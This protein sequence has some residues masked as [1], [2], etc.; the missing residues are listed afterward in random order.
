MGALLKDE[1]IKGFEFSDCRVQ[2]SRLAVL[3]ACDAAERGADIFTRTKVI[4]A[5]RDGK[6]WKI[7]LRDENGS[8]EIYA[9]ALVNAGGPWMADIV[10]NTVN[11]E[12][13]E[14]IRLVQG[15]HIV[16]EKLFDHDRAYFFQGSDNRIIFYYTV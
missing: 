4:G 12:T 6:I 15:S 10:K 16:T 9:K 5:E 13:N 3:N 1:F 8:R 7:T 2:D 14:E 11:F